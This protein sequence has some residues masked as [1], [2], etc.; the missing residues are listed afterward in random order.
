MEAR[1]R[2][3][4]Q[5]ERQVQR[6]WGRRVHTH[7]T[8]REALCVEQVSGNEGNKQGLCL[9]GGEDSEAHGPKRMA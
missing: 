8:R 3:C 4:L 5:R 6:P 7:Q 9:G 1:E 2:P